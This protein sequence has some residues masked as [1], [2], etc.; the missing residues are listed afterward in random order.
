MITFSTVILWLKKWFLSSP[1]MVLTSQ[2][3]NLNHWIWLQMIFGY[4]QNSDKWH[5][6][7]SLKKMQKCDTGSK[8]VL[9]KICSLKVAYTIILNLWWSSILK[10]QNCIE[11]ILGMGKHMPKYH[12]PSNVMERVTVLNST[13]KTR[14]DFC[15]LNGKFIPS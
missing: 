7:S 14:F 2:I 13:Q 8:T 11:L 1:N 6:L 9:R 15:V 12:W 4:S 5:T 10:V 3:I